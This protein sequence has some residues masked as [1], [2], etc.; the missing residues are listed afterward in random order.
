[1]RF[2][3]KVSTVAAACALAAA[4][5]GTLTDAAVAQESRT[6]GASHGVHATLDGKTIDLSKSWQRAHTCSVYTPTKVRCWDT[7]S[8]ADRAMGVDSAADDGATNALKKPACPEDWVCLYEHENGGG[9]RLQFSDDYWDN[10]YDYGFSNQ[11]SSWR[12][13]QDGWGND[14]AWLADGRG[15][16]GK[17]IHLDEGGYT[18]DLGRFNDKASSVYG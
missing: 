15:G 9:R 8:E 3:A 12:N 13:N 10:L 6:A 2:T 5:T 16:K 7:K 1:M 11:T 4:V 17:Q 18:S 14:R